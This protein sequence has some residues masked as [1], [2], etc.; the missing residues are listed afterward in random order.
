MN[1]AVVEYSWRDALRSR[2]STSPLMWLVAAPVQIFGI[3]IRNSP[4]HPDRAVAIVVL[5]VIAELAVLLLL[6]LVARQRSPQGRV[7]SMTTG[8]V[9]LVWVGCG[10]LLSFIMELGV[11]L[12]IGGGGIGLGG[13]LL[14]MIGSTLALFG[15]ATIVGAGVRERQAD[16]V[17]LRR[18]NDQINELGA[19]SQR[20]AEDQRL[21]LSDALDAVVIPALEQLADEADELN[22]ATHS[23]LEPLRSRVA[24]YSETIIRSLSRE[25]SGI[26][27]QW[28][29]PTPVTE[30]ERG[31]TLRGLLD[32]L[33][34]AKV[35]ILPS[36]AFIGVILWAQ[37][38]PSC[39]ERDALALASGTLVVVIGRLICR[40][41]F[42]G[43]HRGTGFVNLM[44]YPA[45]GAAFVWSVRTP[46][47]ACEWQGSHQQL[48]GVVG[49]GLTCLA[50]IA[51]A[52]EV[53]R[54][55]RDDASTLASRIRVGEAMAAE[56]DR[57]GERMR[58]QVSLVLHGSVQSRLT[59]VA[60][61]LQVHMDEVSSGGHPDKR[62]LL[63]RVTMLLE[64]AAADVQS[65]F[66]EEP[67]P[68]S[69]DKQMQAMRTRWLGLLDISWGMS[70]RAA[71]VLG[72]D[73]ECA[74][75][76]LEILGEAITNAS[77]HGEAGS[78]DLRID[79]D[80]ETGTMLIVSATDDGVGPAS[81][82]R[83]GLGTQRI[84]ARGGSWALGVGPEG[85]ARMTVVL[86]IRQGRGA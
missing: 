85:G 41:V 75:W 4:L 36:A 19:A 24:F 59:A 22:V 54:R 62:R 69:V 60:L 3:A 58:D 46:I 78:V 83:E 29:E 82:V 11:D 57:A 31:F 76:V 23:D 8:Q 61:S 65:V 86:P 12:L 15:G 39:P 71:E 30:S 53:T 34:A 81:D 73:P 14:W 26:A 17:R 6:I 35:P 55:S 56:L 20:F 44:I 84:R 66:A 18:A 2:W 80:H 49:I 32:L 48:V 79:V 10:F 77:R 68:A 28:P 37:I 74:A 13:R 40:L 25:V 38:V 16:I 33:M 64:Q 51:M 67:P 5:A 47:V 21:L 52:V 63:A 1:T 43:A 50:L 9:I 45:I 42:Q 72:N 7:P 27:P 70:P